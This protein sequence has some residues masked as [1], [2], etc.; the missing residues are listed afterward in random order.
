VV[1][2]NL[3]LLVTLAD[4]HTAQKHVDALAEHILK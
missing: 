3:D 1:P 2:K 4:G